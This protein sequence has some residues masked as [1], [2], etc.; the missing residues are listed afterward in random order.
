MNS[1]NSSEKVLNAFLNP[2]YRWR[3]VSGIAKETNLTENEV[4]E[5][6][7]ILIDKKKVRKSYVPDADGNNLYGLILRVDGVEV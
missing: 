4:Q 1:N 2:K 5:I 6:L 7:D 3:T